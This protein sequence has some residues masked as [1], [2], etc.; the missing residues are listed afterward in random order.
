MAALGI[1][2]NLVVRLEAE[3]LRKRAIL[4]LLLTQEALQLEGLDRA[5]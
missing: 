5:H 4:L 3:P 2:A 1:V